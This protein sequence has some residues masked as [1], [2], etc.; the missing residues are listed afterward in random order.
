MTL[1]GR[2]FKAADE[3]KEPTSVISPS[4]TEGFPT[5]DVKVL[6]VG[7]FGASVIDVLASAG[8]TGARLFLAFPEEIIGVTPAVLCHQPNAEAPRRQGMPGGME[9]QV[10]PNQCLITL[11]VMLEKT[12]L[13]VL[14]L[15]LEQGADVDTGL[16]AAQCAKALGIFTLAFIGT[17][18]DANNVHDQH[19]SAAFSQL[20][21]AVDT[22]FVINRNEDTTLTRKAMQRTV[23]SRNLAV[24]AIT[25]LIDI[26]FFEGLICVDLADLIY[27]FRKSGLGK[28][29]VGHAR[30]QDSVEL[31]LSV[32]L[33]QLVE[34]QIH[35]DEY[36]R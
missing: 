4:N 15:S 14:V 10:L 12:D 19:T 27:L 24:D 31:A 36:L 20:A 1:T 25:G 16:A 33:Q 29:G 32:A 34:P 17:S 30:G 11:S 18:A 35:S 8:R 6:G 23:W 7:N 13:L 26:L 3:I 21:S 22:Y 5:L 28:I 2:C 9:G